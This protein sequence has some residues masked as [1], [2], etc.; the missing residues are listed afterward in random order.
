M[1]FII[2]LNIIGIFYKFTNLFKNTLMKII[3]KNAIR[4][5]LKN[6]KTIY[7]YKLQI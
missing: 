7:Y 1:L 2:T 4:I 3:D 5:N 6:N